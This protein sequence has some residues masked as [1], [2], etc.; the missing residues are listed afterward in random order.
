MAPAYPSKADLLNNATGGGHLPPSYQT[1]VQQAA[2]PDEPSPA[3]SPPAPFKLCPPSNEPPKDI[4]KKPG[5]TQFTVSVR[6]SGAPVGGLQQADFLVYS[7]S[8][9][10]PIEYFHESA[11][12]PTSIV[13]AIDTSGSMEPKLA[14]VQK[15]L[16]EFLQN[17]NS[18][19]ELAIISFGAR[20]ENTD[21]VEL[22]PTINLIQPFTT[23]HALASTRLEVLKPYGQTPLY[24]S[25][26]EGLRVLAG[27]HY[28]NRA[29]IVITD[30]MDNTSAISKDDVVAEVLKSGWPVYAVGIGD[31]NVP[32]EPQIAIGPFVVG[33][34][35]DRVDAVVLGEFAS[36]SSGR[37]FIVPPMNKDGGQAFVGAVNTI[38][39]L[40]GNQYI[41]GVVIPSGAGWNPGPLP[42]ISVP[43]HPIDIVHVQMIAQA[44]G[45][46]P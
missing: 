9:R 46:P 13:I 22:S 17:L 19:D 14:T 38:S 18:C 35:I 36:A 5:Y 33:N 23:D 45:A 31:P 12:A 42:V 24:D 7:T 3:P 15:T 29:L 2:T 30:G 6:E 4:E 8:Q 10:F 27:A 20:L 44:Q 1:L 16:G 32:S 26:H 43:S 28:L 39:G 40:L 37:A 25:I 21:V 11:D 34:G 41:I